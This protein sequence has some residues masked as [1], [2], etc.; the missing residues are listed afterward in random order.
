MRRLP[1]RPPYTVYLGNLS[2]EC[3]EEDIHRLFERKKLNV[4]FTVVYAIAG[5]LSCRGYCTGPVNTA[6]FG[7]WDPAP[8]G[9]WLCRI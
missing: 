4:S 6:S 3:C 2:Y 9:F 5:L 7:K 1:S 8:E